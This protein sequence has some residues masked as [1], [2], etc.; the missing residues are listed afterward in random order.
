MNH[1]TQ[2]QECRVMEKWNSPV[3]QACR[4]NLKH[5]GQL[6]K[7]NKT[8]GKEEWGKE[9]R[10]EVSEAVTQDKHMLT[11]KQQN[12]DLKDR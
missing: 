10:E 3:G 1:N 7:V 4:L 9:G 6:G 5:P 12:L 8:K 11:I 2:G